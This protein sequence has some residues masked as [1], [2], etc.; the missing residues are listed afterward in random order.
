FVTSKVLNFRPPYGHT[1]KEYI[2]HYTL[3]RTGNYIQYL[4]DRTGN[5]RFLPLKADKRK[6]LVHPVAGLNKDE[7]DL[8]WGEA[9]N[10]FRKYGNTDIFSFTQSEELIIEEHRQEFIYLNDFETSIIDYLENKKGFVATRELA[11]EVFDEQNIARN[12]KL[13][14]SIK[15]FM[16]SLSGE[17]KESSSYP[18]G[19]KTRGYRR[20]DERKD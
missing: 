11:R 12:R 20:I 14:K 17:W 15:N 5:R 16:E 18:N 4:V 13:S 2:R 10:L 6:Q 19:K 1:D 8:I 3:A 7:V 9:V